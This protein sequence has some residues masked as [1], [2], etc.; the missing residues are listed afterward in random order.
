M[1]GKDT[2][3]LP[4]DVLGII[5]TD[6][7]IQRFNADIEG[8][9]KAAQELPVCNTRTELQSVVLSDRSP[10]IGKTLAQGD[11][12]HVYHAM[13]LRVIDHDGAERALTPDMGFSPGD[14]LWL[15]GD[16]DYIPKLK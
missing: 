12:R 2:R 16:P 13:L 3:I 5:G 10:L 4:G 6:D 15:V 8:Y 11:I 7:Q 1:P 14:T 9:K